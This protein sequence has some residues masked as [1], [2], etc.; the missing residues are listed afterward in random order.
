VV[1]GGGGARADGAGGPPDAA[2]WALCS[3]GAC[4]PRRSTAEVFSQKKNK[5]RESCAGVHLE[6]LLQPI[7]LRWTVHN[8]FVHLCTGVSLCI[9]YAPN[10]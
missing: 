5:L 7:I 6:D 2:L 8:Y 1:D 4:S 9:K 10:K 3:A